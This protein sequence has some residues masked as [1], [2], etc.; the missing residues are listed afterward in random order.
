[1]YQ[2][3]NNL[4]VGLLFI[5]H[6]HSVINCAGGGLNMRKRYRQDSMFGGVCFF[7]MRFLFNEV[8]YIM[9]ALLNLPTLRRVAAEAG[10]KC[11]RTRELFITEPF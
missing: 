10:K 1:M 4:I 5:F 6:Y 3:H 11:I 9:S 8:I 7:S 2:G